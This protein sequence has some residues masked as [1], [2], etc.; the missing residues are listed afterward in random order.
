M[1]F[2][3]S[4]DRNDGLT[5]TKIKDKYKE[6]GAVTNITPKSAVPGIPNYKLPEYKTWKNMRTRCNNPNH[7]DYKFYGAKGIYVCKS[8]D[9]F[10]KFY[11][12][13]GPRPNKS[14]SI[15]RINT[16]GPYSS[17]NCRW[18]TKLEQVNNMKS[19][20]LLTY[21]NKTMTV[22]ETSRYYELNYDRFR[23]R[24]QRGWTTKRAIETP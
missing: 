10:N 14:Y 1:A 5:M 22:A 15:D 3:R 17:Q 6:K 7:K 21:K 9:S 19:N 18:A 2:G 12:D 11:S 20:R 23:L 4:G 24:I 8:W 16:C 13:M